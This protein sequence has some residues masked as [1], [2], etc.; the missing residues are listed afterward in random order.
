[1]FVYHLSKTVNSFDDDYKLHIIYVYYTSG[2][3][4]KLTNDDY[5][6]ILKYI[7]SSCWIATKINVHMLPFFCED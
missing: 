6:A 7:F 2:I 1:M 4:I 5:N 3:I